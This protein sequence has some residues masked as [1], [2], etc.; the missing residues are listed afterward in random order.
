M[1][2]PLTALLVASVFVSGCNSRA[3]PFNWFGGGRSAPVAAAED[4]NPLIPT[5]GVRLFQRPEAEDITVP[6]A[7]VTELRIEPDLSGA[8]VTATGIASRQGAFAAE[9]RPTSE[10]LV[11]E[12]GVLTFDFVV[13][14]PEYR[15]AT[16]PAQSRKVVVGYDLSRQDL[17]R[18]RSIRVVGQTNALESRQR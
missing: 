12:N 5:G 16:G 11:P 8:I 17:Q 3:N 2:K 7:S 14:Y 10:D 15:T 6:I 4:V 1:H 18:V 9:L 13:A